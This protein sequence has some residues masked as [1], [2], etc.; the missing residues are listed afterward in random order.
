MPSGVGA[1]SII[2]DLP[3]TR[4]TLVATD[5]SGMI[6][7][8]ADAAKVLQGGGTVAFPTETVYGLGADANSAEAVARIYAAKGRPSF[9]PL[10]THVANL[11]TAEAQGCFSQHALQLAEAFWP[12]PLTLVLPLAASATVCSLARAGLDSIAI[13]IPNHPIARAL[14]EAAGRP[15]A[16][17]SANR[18]GHMSP[19]TAAH[20]LEDLNGAIDLI[21]DGG[22]TLV[23]V[24]STIIACL[25]DQPRLLRPGGIAREDVET[26]LG[27]SLKDSSASAA[28]IAPGMM[29]SH[30]APRARL[31]LE[32]TTLNAT[33][34]GL[35]FGGCF[36][37][38]P[39]VLDLSP[40]GDL[41][42]AAAHLFDY[43]HQLDRMGKPVIAVAPIP[44]RGLGEAINDR[45]ARA[46]APR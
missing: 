42:E 11:K 25:D 33:E 14:I 16:A 22:P 35:D 34:G 13:R 40:S 38:G 43:L 29:A 20:V 45:L 4:V 24:E 1:K 3:K 5:A 18:S 32:A 30:Y 36:G 6:D 26:V 39:A 41:N 37:P 44:Q 21:L 2:N 7:A 46:A 17:P 23:G 9:N 12:G 31:R 10:I 27:L 28:L 8:I 19:V 15:L